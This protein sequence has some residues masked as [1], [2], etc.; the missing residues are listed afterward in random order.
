MVQQ[1]SKKP[2]R[3]FN[4]NSAEHYIV[5][6]YPEKRPSPQGAKIKLAAFDLDWTLIKPK[7]GKTFAKNAADWKFLKN[8][9]V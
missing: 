6:I 5:G 9:T 3:Y 4:Y 2:V 8:N 7:S 1:V